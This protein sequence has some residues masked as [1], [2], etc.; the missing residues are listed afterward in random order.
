MGLCAG[1]AA[2]PWVL[3]RHATAGSVLAAWPPCWAAAIGFWVLARPLGRRL[4]APWAAVFALYVAELGPLDPFTTAGWAG[5]LLLLAAARQAF[6][7]PG[8]ARAV[9]GWAV[10][11]LCGAAFS[12]TPAAGALAAAWLVHVALVSRPQRLGNTAGAFCRAALAGAL[13]YGLYMGASVWL[14]E[15][16]PLAHNSLDGLRLRSYAGWLLGSFVAPQRALWAWGTVLTLCGWLLSAARRSYETGRGFGAQITR[17]HFGARPWLLLAA[18]SSAAAVLAPLR[19]SE[20]WDWYAA[21]VAPGMLST[22]LGLRTVLRWPRGRCSRARWLAAAGAALAA[23]GVTALIVQRV[24][25]LL[26]LP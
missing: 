5:I 16:A 26:D 22:M 23:C 15:L 11:A 9:T 19:T 4:A 10:G 13:G 17:F 14:P 21:L 3:A 18:W 2:V 25:P 6:A 1:A 20:P 24:R 8:G 12:A 7:D